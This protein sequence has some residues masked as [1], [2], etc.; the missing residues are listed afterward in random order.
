MS[1]SQPLLLLLLVLTFESL[2]VVTARETIRDDLPILP[3]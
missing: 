3:S 2:V 1:V